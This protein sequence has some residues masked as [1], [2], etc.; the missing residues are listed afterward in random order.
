M[1]LPPRMRT[2]LPAG[3]RTRL[4]A[5]FAG[6]CRA[7]QEQWQM[8]K[9]VQQSR[10]IEQ[11]ACIHQQN[12][13]YGSDP[14]CARDHQGDQ[15]ELAGSGVYHHGRQYCDVRRKPRLQCGETER[16]RD[17][18]IARCNRQTAEQPATKPAGSRNGRRDRHNSNNVSAGTCTLRCQSA[19]PHCSWCKTKTCF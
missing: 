1:F 8:W 10:A 3:Q 17:G 19:P 18:Q 14:A 4:R 9:S 2:H 16:E 7:C 15:H 6:C 5:R 11:V 12:G 13:R